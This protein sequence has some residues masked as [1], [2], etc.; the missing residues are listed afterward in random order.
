MWIRLCAAL[1]CVCRRSREASVKVAGRVSVAALAATAVGLAASSPP[2]EAAGWNCEASAARAAVLGAAAR[3]A[4]RR[5]QGPGALPRRQRRSARPLPAPLGVNTL[6]ASTGVTG[7]RQ[8]G[9][10][11]RH[12][13]RRPRRPRAAAR[14]TC[15]SSCR[16]TRSSTPSRRSVPAGARRC[17]PR[18][19]ASTSARRCA[20]RDRRAAEHRPRCA[21]A[22]PSRTRAAAASERRPPNAR[23]L[24]AR[25]GREPARPGARRRPGRQPDARAASA[26]QSIDPSTLD[27]SKI[28]LPDGHRAG[29][30]PL[31]Q[32]AI[33]PALD[34]LP[35][36]QLPGDARADRASTPGTQQRTRRHARSSA[37]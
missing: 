8:P 1:R 37:R 26:A 15:R 14:S 12:R 24:L 27:I 31:V 10:P 30:L 6:A 22:P 29:L 20:P 4:D 17:R 23:R 5:Q 16:S 9:R 3:R 35:N 18:P 21:S 13:D 2:R 32:A 7:G 28:Q 34:A 25:R 11:G 19:V 36:I 33:Q